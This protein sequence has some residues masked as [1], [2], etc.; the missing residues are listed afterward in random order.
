[1]RIV[2]SLLIF[3]VFLGLLP[4][5]SLAADAPKVCDSCLIRVDNLDQPIKLAGNWQFTRDDSPKNKEVDADTSHW[6]LAKAPGPWKNIYD[7]KKN[8]MV[9][10]YR[11]TFEFN[12][13]LQGKEVVLLLNTY[14]ARMDVYV[15][16]KEVFQRPHDMNVER[17]YSIQAAPVRFKV[18]KT[19]HVVT[20]RVATPL[21]AGV[22]GLPFEMHK[23]DQHDK[24][25]V[26][27]QVYGGEARVIIAYSLL[28]FGLFFLGVFAKTRYPLYLW[29]G[30]G[31]TVIFPF[32]AAPGDYW[33]KLVAP[34]P[35]VY[36]HYV[37]LL[38][39]FSIQM[40][41]QYL[42]HEFMPKRNVLIG[43]TYVLLCGTIGSM[44]VHPNL[45][46]FQLVRPLLLVLVLV[47]SLPN[48]TM[49]YRAIRAKKTGGKT[50]MVAALLLLASGFNDVG[51][52]LGKIAS[53]PTISFGVGFFM[54]SMLVIATR[55][56]AQTFM[57][58]K[59]L[60]KDL[61]SMNDNLESLVAERTEQLREKTLD[62]QSMLQNMPQGVLTVT[63][64][65]NIHPE[66]SAYLETIFETKEIAGKNAIELFFKDS[67]IGSDALSQ[68]E[69]AV[70]S[71]IGEDSMNFEFNSHLFVTE[72]DK[73]LADGRIKSLELGWS[74]ICDAND[75]VEKLMICVRDVTELKRLEKE[76]G[77]QKRE[78]EI[79]GQILAVSQEK[80]NDFI[81]GSLKFIEDNQNL[82]Q[83]SEL[84]D[85]ER[86]N[87]LFRNMHTIKGNARTYGLSHMTNLVHETEQAYD[88]LR[89]ND[90]A[91]WV[92]QSL[93]TQ[94]DAVKVLVDEH[95]RINEHV[96]GRKGPGRRG[97]VE[98]YLMVEKEQ[99][100]SSLRLASDVDQ[101]DI[102]ALRGAL[103]QISRTLNLIGTDRFEDVVAG[104]V[105]SLPSLAKELGKEPPVVRI[106][107][108]GIV[109]RN[110]VS[111]LLKNLFTHL[112]RNSMDH[113]LED[114]ETR[115]AHGK[116]AAG[117]I[118]L[119]LSVADGQLIIRL[120][121]DGRGMAIA[122]IRER[123]LGL[124]MLTAEEARS[125]K[126]VAMM[127]FASGFSTAEQVTEVS[128]RGVGMDA[129]KGFLEKEGGSIDVRF[130][131]DTEANFRPFELIIT[132]PGKFAVPSDLAQRGHAPGMASLNAAAV[133]G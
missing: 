71:C 60:V 48:F 129:V 11:G 113:G 58:N 14:M 47:A 118:D 51:L 42:F 115:Q 65:Y 76:A 98:K 61:K 16:G 103:N 15:D 55:I 127:I 133:A 29:A 32:F 116:P 8:F 43:V 50:I 38:G 39:I 30:L 122:K 45:D 109:V 19:R 120:R 107:D 89:K 44:I 10:W 25:L 105:D 92:S 13:E 99:V 73:T 101:N 77:A 86:V 83:G 94:L 84:K 69:A 9:G 41:T 6:K 131:D 56:F 88:E 64:D 63:A 95:A 128:G 114:A 36:L 119:D 75:M 59:S 35:L 33:L 62:I 78:L 102:V 96:L 111:G 68:V 108:R 126:A 130:L 54:M 17:Y 97:S 37:G 117:R 12:P 104:I 22:Y 28:T 31:G 90:E 27:H 24:S 49:A 81:D 52:A 132:L 87:L 5:I 106:E 85:L 82:I 18:S 79:I 91:E 124:Q 26:F 121:D 93:L 110:Q 2:R 57:D 112:L 23:Y 80:F 67:S 72:I 3:A 74:A 100:E 46:L 34:E 53:V 21:M 40:F 4:A 125:A 20:F 66:Y 7:D 1:M 70:S 123:A